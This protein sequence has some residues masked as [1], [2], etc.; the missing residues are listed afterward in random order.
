MSILAVSP[1]FWTVGLRAPA[2]QRSSVGGSG[3]VAPLPV[4][5][6]CQSEWNALPSEV[7]SW[8]V[9]AAGQEPSSEGRA[10]ISSSTETLFP[11]YKLSPMDMAPGSSGSECSALASVQEMP[12]KDSGVRD[13]QHQ[14]SPAL[15][16]ARHQSRNRSQFPV[17]KKQRRKTDTQHCGYAQ[18][19]SCH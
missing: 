8:R 19:C 9:A 7:G 3:Q 13:P 1:A 12:R 6:R 4:L 5:L 10:A 2:G 15:S 16:M 14:H 18:Y 11:Q 17:P